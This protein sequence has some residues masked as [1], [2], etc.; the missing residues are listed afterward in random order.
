MTTNAKHVSGDSSIRIEGCRSC[1]GTRLDSF[2]DL[3]NMPLADGLLRQEQLDKPEPK[4]PLE[5]A[6]CSDCALVQIL[7]TVPPEEL[8]QPIKSQ[9]VSTHFLPPTGY[10]KP[11]IDGKKSHY[12]EWQQAGFFDTLKAG[13][14]MHQV[15]SLVSGIYFGSDENNI[16]FRRGGQC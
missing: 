6:I 8:Y 3:G 12:Y 11:T 4:Y 15:S 10:L 7:D 16:Y 9:A 1:G 5:V 13:G 14:A 2:L